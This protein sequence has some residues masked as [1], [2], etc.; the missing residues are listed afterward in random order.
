MGRV[1]ITGM[2]IYSSLGKNL[3]EVCDSLYHGRS[4][5]VF[6]Q[7]RKDFGCRSAL[8]GSVARPDLTKA[9]SR[10]QRISMG[11]ESEYAY[12]ATQEALQ[13][14][15]IEAS[16]FDERV[17]GLVYGNDSVSQAVLEP[18]DIVRQK[19]DTTLV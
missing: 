3:E 7:E 17:V 19:Q 11:E 5:I 15:G 12:V 2:G 6:S 16:F 4:G 13:L 10:R 9:L 18:I 8:M 14:A 1:V